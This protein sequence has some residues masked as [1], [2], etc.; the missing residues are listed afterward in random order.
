MIVVLFSPKGLP[1]FAH[2]LLLRLSATQQTVMSDGQMVL[3]CHTNGAQLFH[4]SLTNSKLLIPRE[5][6]LLLFLSWAAFW[7]QPPCSSLH[8]EVTFNR[9]RMDFKTRTV[10]TA[11]TDTDLTF[12]QR[13]AMA[14][15]YEDN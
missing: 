10:N 1:H 3:K 12:R 13:Y 8:F 4:I 11:R 7:T 6:L 9:N 5:L 14:S 2:H 15:D